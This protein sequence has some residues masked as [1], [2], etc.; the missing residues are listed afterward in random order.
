[1][2]T[3]VSVG[4]FKQRVRS[5]TGSSPP[6]SLGSLLH[7][8]GLAAR[9]GSEFASPEP[10]E[11]ELTVVRLLGLPD[12]HYPQCHPPLPCGVHRQLLVT[13]IGVYI[14]YFLTKNENYQNAKRDRDLYE[15]MRQHPEDFKKPEPKTMAEL[16]EPWVPIR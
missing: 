8:H 13:S 9:R 11:Q 10:G 7:H 14:G 6:V 12:R 15:Y 4:T 1:M 3:S 5:V 2:W 16:L